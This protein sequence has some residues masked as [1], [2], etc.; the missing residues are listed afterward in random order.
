MEE[1]GKGWGWF[2][3]LCVGVMCVVVVSLIE[4]FFLGLWIDR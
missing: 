2:F 4:D 1:G 3:W